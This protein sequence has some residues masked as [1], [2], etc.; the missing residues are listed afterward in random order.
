[1]SAERT[2]VV[3]KPTR[4]SGESPRDPLAFEKRGS[5]RGAAPP[6]GRPRDGGEALRVHKGKFFYN[7]LVV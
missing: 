1:M 5:A 7:D 3:L 2:L 4:L 6:E